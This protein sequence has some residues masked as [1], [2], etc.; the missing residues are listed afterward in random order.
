MAANGNLEDTLWKLDLLNQAVRGI[1]HRGAAGDILDVDD[2]TLGA[3]RLIQDV[4]ADLERAIAGSVER[5]ETREAA[6]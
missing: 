6:A 4:K 3:E 1:A 2:E 5:L